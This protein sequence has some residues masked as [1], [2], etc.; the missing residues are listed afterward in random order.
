LIEGLVLKVSKGGSGNW[1]S[2]AMTPNDPKGL[3]Q[4]EITQLVQ[5]EQGLAKK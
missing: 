1:G 3:H 2:V 4:A 5:F